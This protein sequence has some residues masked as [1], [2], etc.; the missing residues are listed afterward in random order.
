MYLGMG[1]IPDKWK[2]DYDCLTCT[3][4]LVPGHIPP[5]KGFDQ[6]YDVVKSGGYIVFSVRDRYYESTGVK[7]KTEQMV[8]DGKMKHLKSYC[9]VRNEEMDGEKKTVLFYP[10]PATVYVYLRV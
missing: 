8:K 1:D 2:K 5:G 3:G 4:S 10:E 7:E 6:M 9:W